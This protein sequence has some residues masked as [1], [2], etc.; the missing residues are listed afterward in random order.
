MKHP[1]K[2]WLVTCAVAIGAAALLAPMNASA[3]SE[4]LFHASPAAL[5][6][7]QRS[8]SNVPEYSADPALDAGRLADPAGNPVGGATVIVFPVP[9]TTG[10]DQPLTPIAR[11]TTDAAGH[12]TIHLPY[13]KR[14][15]LQ[16][17]RHGDHLNLH[18]IAFYP[19]AIANWFAPFSAAGHAIGKTNLVLQ[20]LPAGN[21]ARALS[22]SLDPPVKCRVR[23]LLTLASTRRSRACL[24][25][26]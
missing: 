24:P 26:C 5:A 6:S 15:L 9:E 2:T 25:C 13:A 12:F 23:R 21:E 4:E 17:F 3:T 8:W 1:R 20:D 11:A 22:L 7:I 10:K 19:N 18:I 14:S 16:G